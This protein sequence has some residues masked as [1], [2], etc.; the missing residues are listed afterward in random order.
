V[1]HLSV[2]LLYAFPQ[3]S[4]SW[5]WYSC[6]A[7]GILHY[8]GQTAGWMKT[9]L[10]TEVDIGTGHFVLDGFPALHEWGTA[11]PPLFE[12]HVCCGHGCPSQLLL[13]SCSYLVSLLCQSD[14]PMK[15]IV[16]LHICWLTWYWHWKKAYR[17]WRLL[18]RRP[19]WSK[20]REIC[21]WFSLAG[22]SGLNFLQCFDTVGFVR[23]MPS[24]MENPFHLFPVVL[25]WTDGVRKLKGTG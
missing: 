7:S 10:G 25:F 1:H 2:L 17:E 21:R 9:P 14:M 16:N 15:T 12:A 20:K 8:C 22:V 13:S 6:A 3:L 18:L 23:G 19:A 5:Y 24:A 4:S 11:P